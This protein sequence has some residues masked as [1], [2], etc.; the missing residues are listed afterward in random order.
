MSVIC[1]YPQRVEFLGIPLATFFTVA[2][3]RP[4]MPGS[5]DFGQS[6]L[7]RLV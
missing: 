6:D 4:T 1:G 3:V 5:P 2:Q 7:E